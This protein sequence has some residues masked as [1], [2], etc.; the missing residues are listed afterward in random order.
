MVYGV[1]YC[2]ID[3]TNVLEALGCADSKVLTEEKRE[4]IFVKMVTE[5]DALCNVGWAAEI[6]SPN[7]ISNSMYK[8]AK[9][10]LNE[11]KNDYIKKSFP[12]SDLAKQNIKHL[13][14][15]GLIKG[16]S[17]RNQKTLG[18]KLHQI[19]TWTRA[20]TANPRNSSL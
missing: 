12:P 13:C 5:D 15:L 19:L 11:V 3:K 14:S 8:R 18:T 20:Q 16:F 1:A 6:I 4:E 2:P 7:Y 10:S 9:H 17:T